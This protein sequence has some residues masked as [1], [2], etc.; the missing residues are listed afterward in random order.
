VSIP[1]K[2]PTRNA[3]DAQDSS[4]PQASP[5]KQRWVWGIRL[6]LVLAPLIAGKLLFDTF[7]TD[8]YD[9]IPAARQWPDIVLHLASHVPTARVAIFVVCVWVLFFLAAAIAVYE[10]LRA[11]ATHFLGFSFG[12][13][14]RLYTRLRALLLGC[15][16]LGVLCVLY[17]FY[18]E[19]YWLQVTHVR[20]ASAKLPTAAPPI[21]LAVISDLHMGRSP[22]LEPKLPG[23]IAEQ[24]PDLIFFL[25]DAMNST[26]ALGSFKQLMLT[27]HNIAPVVAVRGNQ[28]HG[29]IWDG[30]VYEGTQVIELRAAEKRVT[31]RGV[32]LYIWGQDYD[33]PILL[34]RY[35]PPP[36]GDF[37]ILVQHSPDLMEGA[38]RSKFDLYLAGH[39][40]GGQIALPF[41]GA[42][43]T[44]SYYDKKY[45][46]GLF[47]EG[48]TTL[49][50]N[51]GIGFARWPQ[52]EARFFARPEVTVIDLVG[53]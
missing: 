43:I 15:A 18:I 24:K 44:Y 19:P 17:G 14:I 38:V 6:L 39:T 13:E 21:R 48:S 22:K 1:P 34:P 10:Y 9:G 35:P 41:Y 50:V 16:C 33:P 25:G 8:P 42:L 30:D 2:G 49:Y 11:F 28:D 12:R 5:R 31:I 29:S 23:V 20:V 37:T 53:R 46:S 45:E 47:Q 26:W 27:L 36:P 3:P 40:H 52:P 51:R 32:E 4:R 7:H